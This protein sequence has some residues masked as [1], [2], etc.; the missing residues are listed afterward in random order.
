MVANKEKWPPYIVLGQRGPFGPVQSSEVP[1]IH[2]TQWVK[3]IFVFRSHE[4]QKLQ[5]SL[6]LDLRKWR[7]GKAKNFEL[8]Y[9][10]QY[11]SV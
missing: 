4:K 3:I 1:K 11:W 2:F 6:L 10:S 8:S 7:T 5:K 9:L